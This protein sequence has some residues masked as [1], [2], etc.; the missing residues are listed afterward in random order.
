MKL[1][2]HTEVNDK[3]VTVNADLNDEEVEELVK[4]AIY[5]LI[6]KGKFPIQQESDMGAVDPMSI[7]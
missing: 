5:D 6:L 7:N 3:P 2:F 4:Y 1:H